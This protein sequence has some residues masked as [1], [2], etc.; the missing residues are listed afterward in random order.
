MSSLALTL[1]RLPGTAVMHGPDVKRVIIA[2][3]ILSH[4]HREQM[5]QPHR[6]PSTLCPNGRFL[7]PQKKRRPHGR[8]GDLRTSLSTF[9]RGSLTEDVIVPARMGAYSIDSQKLS[10]DPS[11]GQHCTPARL[12]RIIQQRFYCNPIRCYD[13]PGRE[14]YTARRAGSPLVVPTSSPSRWR[15]HTW[16]SLFLAPCAPQHPQF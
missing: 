6:L 1:C 4:K 15:A 10:R 16:R 11:A 14:F 5:G 9:N 3:L 13:K 8:L 7:P 2:D 12:A